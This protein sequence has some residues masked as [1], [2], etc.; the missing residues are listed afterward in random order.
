MRRIVALALMALMAIA[1]AAPAAVA[2]ESDTFDL[3]VRHR[4]NGEPLGLDRDLPVDVYANGGYV[5]TFE[6]ADN[7]NAE[8]P[9][10]EY[11]FE[12]KLAGTNTTVLSLGSESDPV[13]IPGGVDVTVTAKRMGQDI[14][15]KVG[16]K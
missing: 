11:W 2:Q 8:L 6:K 5:F 10:G 16:I 4:I 9:A 15:L 14:G 12:V 13:A 3:S 1:I 7:F